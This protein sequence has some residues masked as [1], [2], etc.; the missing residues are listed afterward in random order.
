[1][2]WLHLPYTWAWTIAASFRYI[3][4]FQRETN[5]IVEAQLMRGVPLDGS[6]RDK[7]KWV[8][9]ILIPLVYRLHV[10]TI[11][12]TEALYAKAWLPKGPKTFLYPLQLA[13]PRNLLFLTGFLLYHGYVLMLSG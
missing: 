3:N 13:T 4:L 7:L 5:E 12:L 2:V 8:P 1:M 6:L 9:A 10:R 11:Q